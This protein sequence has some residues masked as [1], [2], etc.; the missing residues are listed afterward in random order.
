MEKYQAD[1]QLH[2]ASS[3]GFGALA[4][5]SGVWT[6]SWEGEGKKS[7]RQGLI[8]DVAK[9]VNRRFHKDCEDFQQYHDI[10]CDDCDGANIAL[11]PVQHPVESSGAL[12]LLR[13]N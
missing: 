4:V 8:P 12:F 9:D 13:D 3:Q 2:P 7:G 1:W 10:F 11:H 6:F 5:A